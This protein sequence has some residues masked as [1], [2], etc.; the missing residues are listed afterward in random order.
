MAAE[1][2]G[3]RWSINDIVAPVE[4][5]KKKAG[6]VCNRVVGQSETD[7]RVLCKRAPSFSPLDFISLQFAQRS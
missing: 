7:N 1:V 6:A 5:T 4:P 3:K 2:S